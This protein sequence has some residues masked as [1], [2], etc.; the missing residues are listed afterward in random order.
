MCVFMSVSVFEDFGDCPS[1]KNDSISHFSQS[2]VHVT[3]LSSGRGNYGGAKGG[4]QVTV[5]YSDKGA[6]RLRRVDGSTKYQT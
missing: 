4:S 5:L 3:Q 1:K 2:Y 6:M